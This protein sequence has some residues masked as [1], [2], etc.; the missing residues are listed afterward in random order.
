MSLEEELLKRSNSKC[1]LC[2]ALTE[3]KVYEVPPVSTGGAD[4]NLLACSICIEQVENADIT[5]PNHWR[6]LND[7]MWSEFPA[8]KVVVYR[9]LSRLRK[10]G[11]PQDLLDMMYLEDEVLS[12]ANSTGEGLDESE[13]VIHRD[14][15]GVILEAGD[16]VILIKDLLVKGSSMVAKRGTAVRRISL[17]TENADYIEGKVEGQQI[18][19]ITKFVKKL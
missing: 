1:E 13:K 12:W 9:M 11:W 15:N 6:C 10:E 17:D 5:D 8:V 19:I 4:G 7:S 14:T 16:S 18:V 2:G 3:I